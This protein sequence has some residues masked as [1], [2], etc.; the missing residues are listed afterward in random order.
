MDK[1]AI[2]TCFLR[3]PTPVTPPFP[4]PLPRPQGD[5]I[6]IITEDESGWWQGQNQKTGDTGIFP[7]VYLAP[8]EDGAIATT[9]P[10]AHSD[11]F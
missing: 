8:K 6:T 5:I 11:T 7:A 1:A 3:Y 9:P 2:V 4:P 10:S